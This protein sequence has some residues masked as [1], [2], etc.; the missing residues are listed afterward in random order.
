MGLATATRLKIPIK[1]LPYAVKLVTIDEG[2]IG[3]GRIK[4]CTKPIHMQISSLP[5]EIIP[6]LFIDWNKHVIILKD[7]WLHQHNP[8]ILYHGLTEKSL[9]GPATERTTACQREFYKSVPLL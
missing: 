4:Y 9:H 2:P 6:F 8:G 3:T 1:K 5:Q 7:P